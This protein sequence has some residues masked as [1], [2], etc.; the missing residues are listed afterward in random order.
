MR[1]VEIFFDD[2]FGKRSISDE[3][4]K[5]YTALHLSL[6]TSDGRF[7]SLATKTNELQ[8]RFLEASEGQ[9]LETLRTD[10][11]KQLTKNLLTVALEVADGSEAEKA[12]ALQLFPQHLLEPRGRLGFSRSRYRS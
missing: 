12:E 2:P 6:L 4:L 7:P 1:N 5:A 11:T 10:L 9:D 8:Q 3:D